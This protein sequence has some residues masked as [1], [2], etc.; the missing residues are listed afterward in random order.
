MPKAGE[1]KNMPTSFY[2]TKELKHIRRKLRKTS[3][4]AEL[5]LW[6]YLR[7]GRLQGRKFRRQYSIGKY[8]LD[9]Y[10]PQERIAIELDGE[11]HHTDK[12]YEHDV[13]RDRFLKEQNIILIR[14]EN[15]LVFDQLEFVLNTVKKQFKE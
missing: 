9:F 5:S 11:V 13:I 7:N 3:T 15:H 6:K 12:I 14:F 4:P 1:V 2:N 8:I 10:C